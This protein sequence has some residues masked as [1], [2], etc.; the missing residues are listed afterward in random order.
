MLWH[1]SET[2]AKKQRRKPAGRNDTAVPLRAA[3]EAG[4]PQALRS[5]SSLLFASVP[6]LGALPS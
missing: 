2:A 3:A 4:P 1:K 6:P 5:Q